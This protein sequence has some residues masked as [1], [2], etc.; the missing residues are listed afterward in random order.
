MKATHHH[1]IL[2]TMLFALA[3]TSHAVTRDDLLGEYY[4][5]GNFQYI[6]NRNWYYAYNINRLEAGEGDN[7]I[8][9]SDYTIFYN[10]PRLVGYFDAENS[11]IHLPSG[12]FDTWD[13]DPDIEM[14]M[15]PVSTTDSINYTVQ[16]GDICLDVDPVT[17]EI[18]SHQLWAGFHYRAGQGGTA[19]GL[20]SAYN[21]LRSLKYTKYTGNG[22]T[23]YYRRENG[24]TYHYAQSVYSTLRGDT[25]C[26]DYR[27]AQYGQML[28][29]ID[30]ATKTA[31]SVEGIACQLY[32]DDV[33][34]GT[35]W[36][37][38][39]IVGR[40]TGE[41]NNILEIPGWN[42]GIDNYSYTDDFYN[43]RITTPF[44]L[45][46]GTVSDI[47]EAERITRDDLLGSYFM[48]YRYCVDSLKWRTSASSVDITTGE[49][50]N[51]LCLSRFANDKYPVGGYFD[52]ERQSIFVEKQKV[53][54]DSVDYYLESF[55]LV[56][57]RSYVPTIANLVLRRDVTTGNYNHSGTW[58]VGRYTL[59]SLG[60]DPEYLD[61]PRLYHQFSWLCQDI[62]LVPAN[63]KVNETWTK[64]RADGSY[65]EGYTYNAA[66][67]LS[68]DT[69]YI[70]NYFDYGQNAA[71]IINRSERT[72]SAINQ[73]INVLEDSAAYYLM[74]DLNG[75]TTVVGTIG[76]DDNTTVRFTNF[77]MLR[78]SEGE[79]TL[80]DD[81]IAEATIVLPFSLLTADDVTAIEGITMPTA[82]KPRTT[83]YNLQGLRVK[84]PE[85][86]VFIEHTAGAKA[87][88]VRLK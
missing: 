69:L 3:T 43:E 23:S 57:G 76:G 5:E 49:G 29:V 84:A 71:F 40:I 85:H 55:S 79:R 63:T 32:G 16:E 33:Y 10:S 53:W 35:F 50:T 67:R 2:A 1:A 42:Y 24:D 82:A 28:F 65:S 48:R 86:G 30:P 22:T 20:L 74:A 11:Q 38:P 19:E 6:G 31:H 75:N 78:V 12:Y 68:G 62:T 47:P 27:I 64:H 44:D 7:E 58:G 45:L 37:S 25:L 52:P 81:V 59:D 73:V 15:Y 34:I 4:V 87:K 39:G 46:A 18:S 17:G 56:N 72:V 51:D 61:S 60:I 13:E 88:K 66:S 70:D 54:A 80:S 83:Y 26:I 36:G 41:G 21:V 9:F 14:W 77:S 8:I